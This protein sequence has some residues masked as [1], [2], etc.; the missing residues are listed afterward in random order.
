MNLVTG[1]T[2]TVSISAGALSQIVVQ[3]AESVDGARVRRA[4]R[5][6]DV[7]LGD[8]RA[9]VD[10]ELAVRLGAIIPDVAREVQERV[11]DALATMCGVAVE[12]VD[13]TVEELD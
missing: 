13:V 2:G 8:G 5:H 11:A 9:R 12:A 10:L 1:E 7:V 4:R 6:L 3:A